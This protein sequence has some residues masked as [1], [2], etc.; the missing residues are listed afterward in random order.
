MHGS[1]IIYTNL[2]RNYLELCDRRTCTIT[3][4]YLEKLIQK[5]LDC[6]EKHFVGSFVL[7]PQSTHND[8]IRD[9]LLLCG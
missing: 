8:A 6:V 7:H 9:R 5:I 2:L 3:E 4:L 1:Y